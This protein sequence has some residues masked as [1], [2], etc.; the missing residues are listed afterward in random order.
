MQVK[1]MTSH[2]DV[3]PTILNRIFGLQNPIT[4]YSIGHS[5]FNKKTPA[6]LLMHS[7][8]N[9][10]VVNDKKIIAIFPSGYYQIQNLQAKLLTNE[11]LPMKNILAALAL[12][13]R[14]YF[15]DKN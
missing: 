1:H 2:Y 10:G 15:K 13:Q 14:Y 4:D 5:L 7:Y 6:F 11:S 3:V 12:T 8:T 9:L